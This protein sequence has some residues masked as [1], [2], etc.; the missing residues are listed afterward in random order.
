MRVETIIIK[1]KLK[2]CLVSHGL[3]DDIEEIDCFYDVIKGNDK[4]PIGEII[5]SLAV[6][7]EVYTHDCEY[8]V[9]QIAQ[10]IFKEACI[11]YLEV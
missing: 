4:H 3:L 10:I 8:T 7:I 6:F 5:E 11:T 2:S 1:G 9:E